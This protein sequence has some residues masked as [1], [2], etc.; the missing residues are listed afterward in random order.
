MEI[1]EFRAL[2]K[3]VTD[4][5]STMTIDA[6]LDEELNRRFPPGGDVLDT[7]DQSTFFFGQLTRLF[8]IGKQIVAPG[9]HT[10]LVLEL[11]P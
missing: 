9:I 1:S 2:L 7:I 6:K 4:L 5:V 10:V 11:M 8:T 3:P